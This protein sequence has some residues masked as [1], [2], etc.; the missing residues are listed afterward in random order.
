MTL[1]EVGAVGQQRLAEASVLVVGAGGLG[2]PALHHLAASGVGRIG[3]V[4]FDHVD[5]T[6]LHR[7][8]LYSTDDVGKPKIAAARDR[9]LRINPT[10]AVDAYGERLTATNARDLIGA[11]DLVLDGS[12]TFG[13]RYAVNDASVRTRTPLVFASISQF[14]GQASVFGTET[15]PCYRCLFP[16]PPPPDLIPNCA[17]GGVLGVVPSI[18]GTIQAAEAIK[19][20]LGIGSSLVGRLLLVDVLAMEFREIGVERDPGCPA[21]RTG[22]TAETSPDDGSTEIT[23]PELRAR[24]D[25]DVPVLVDVREAAEHHADHI[26]G[27]L[28]PLGQLDVRAFELDDVRDREVVVYCASGGRSARGAQWLRERGFRAVSLRG[29]MDAWNALR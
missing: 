26:G 1:D 6:N 14:S 15:G 9:L 24:M 19:L 8:T 28:I 20:I 25:T 22:R 29:G 16:D 27:R 4:E 12:D 7:Q 11:Y 23:A 17:D 5:V 2:A 13:T 10:V 21:C 18:L 3:I